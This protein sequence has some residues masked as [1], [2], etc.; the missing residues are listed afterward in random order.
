MVTSNSN[1]NADKYL[2]V[3]IDSDSSDDELPKV[4]FSDQQKDDC[5]IIKIEH[6]C[7]K[8]VK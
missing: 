2:P 5:Q 8:S 6:S 4:N 3:L 7:D 1:G